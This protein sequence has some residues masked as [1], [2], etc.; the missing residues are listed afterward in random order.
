MYDFGCSNSY[1]SKDY[2]LIAN[3]K[4]VTIVTPIYYQSYT[5]HPLLLHAIPSIVTHNANVIATN[6]RGL[7]DDT[8][9]Y[10]CVKMIAHWYIKVIHSP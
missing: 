6:I 2:P 10:T 8:R 9:I 5:R 3:S 7:S 1:G 4:I